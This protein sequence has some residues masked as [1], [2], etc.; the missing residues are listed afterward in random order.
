MKEN[1]NISIDV[2]DEEKIREI[3]ESEF[4]KENIELKKVTT[5]L[6]QLMTQLQLE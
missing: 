2:R 5:D 1:S 3:I 6:F 4:F